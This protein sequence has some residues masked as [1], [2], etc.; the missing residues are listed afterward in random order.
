MT[1]MFGKVKAL[2]AVLA[3]LF[4]VAAS[5]AAPKVTGVT[6][7]QRYPW[8]GKVDI[9]VTLSGAAEDV[10]NANCYRLWISDEHA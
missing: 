3:T 7:Q 2:G 5:A 1:N 6:A 9:V 4:G 10:S 8:N